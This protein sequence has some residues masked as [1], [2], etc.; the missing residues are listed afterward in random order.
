MGRHAPGRGRASDSDRGRRPRRGGR[1]RRRPCSQ[2]DDPPGEP[3]RRHRVRHP[4]RR[5]RRPAARCQHR[6]RRRCLLGAGQ[7]HAPAPPRRDPWLGA[8]GVRRVAGAGGLNDAAR[9]RRQRERATRPGHPD[10]GRAGARALRS[11]GRRSHRGAPVLPA[12]RAALRA[13]PH[14]GRPGLRRPGVAD[15]LVRSAL[16]DLRSD[17]ARVIPVCPYVAW[18]IGQHP[19]YASLVYDATA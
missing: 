1:R 18:W 8:D 16:D 3:G 4:P 19:D 5:R 13:H 17:G 15:A 14:R 11:L 10:R 12:H 9:T 6:T 2:S 7:L